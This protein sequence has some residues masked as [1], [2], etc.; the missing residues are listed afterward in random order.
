MDIPGFTKT[1]QPTQLV[2]PAWIVGKY[3]YTRKGEGLDM[4]LTN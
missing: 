1:K 3:H 4:I 2:R